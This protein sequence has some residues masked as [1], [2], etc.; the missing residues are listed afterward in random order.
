MSGSTGTLGPREWG[1]PNL[2]LLDTSDHGLSID[3]AFEQALTFKVWAKLVP[4]TVTIV[5]DPFNYSN[6]SGWLHK[7]SYGLNRS[8]YNCTLSGMDS[9]QVIPFT[10]ETFGISPLASKQ[11]M[12]MNKRGKSINVDI[13]PP[14]APGQTS[15]TTN[16]PDDYIERHW[17]YNTE[18]VK[19]LNAFSNETQLIAACQSLYPFT[20]YHTG[21]WDDEEEAWD[22]GWYVYPSTRAFRLYFTVVQRIAGWDFKYEGVWSGDPPDAIYAKALAATTEAERIAFLNEYFPIIINSVSVAYDGASDEFWDLPVTQLYKCESFYI[23]AQCGE[24]S[25]YSDYMTH[26]WGTITMHPDY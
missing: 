11:A 15:I 9:W 18:L 12:T 19:K 10:L 23:T 8:I 22:S 24:L 25:W 6:Y 20:Y 26:L 7:C 1:Y 5:N 4:G 21:Y 16:L 14:F 17:Q 3:R 13:L 2:G